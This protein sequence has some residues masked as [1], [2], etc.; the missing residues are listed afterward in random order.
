M[1]SFI[2]IEFPKEVKDYLYGLQNKFK[3]DLKKYNVKINWIAKKNLHLTLKF[4]GDIEE[5][6]LDKIK[7]RLDNIEFSSFELNIDGIGFFPGGDYLRVIFIGL[8]PEDKVKELQQEIDQELLDISSKD[9]E[10]H[11]H[12]TLGRIKSVNDREKLKNVVYTD[13]EKIKF[14]VDKFVLMRSQ[15]SRD[16]PKYFLLKA[17][18]AK[19]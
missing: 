12:V 13:I 14:N 16:G 3:K 15:L 8:K 1:R 4:L 2:A 6:V 19:K 5:N 11:A 9:Q 17:F 10:F 7:E 18:K